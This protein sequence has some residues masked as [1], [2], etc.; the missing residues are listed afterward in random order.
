MLHP[1]IFPV[2]VVLKLQHGS[3][4]ENFLSTSKKKLDINFQRR[5]RRRLWNKQLRF[6]IFQRNSFVERKEKN[7]LSKNSAAAP[8][9]AESQFNIQTFN[10]QMTLIII[11]LRESWKCKKKARLT[12]RW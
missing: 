12:Q 8:L 3:K 6:H 2:H 9:T 4:I 10:T 11:T 5:R 7:N 1:Q